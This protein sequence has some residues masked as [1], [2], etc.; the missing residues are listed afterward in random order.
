M[1]FWNDLSKTIYN[2]AG[3]TVK[4]T[5]KLAGIAKIKYKINSLKTKLDFYYK[6]VGEIKFSEYK[7]E[8]ISPETYEGLFEQ[9]DTL[10]IKISELEKKL[11][12]IRE[13]KT[14]PNCAYRVKQ[15]LS[16]CPKCGEKISQ[17]NK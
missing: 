10:N 3:Q 16:F 2:A 9:I 17:D 6:S 4:G 12:D 5:E 7:G 11:S 8:E 15:G 13:Y 1:D 14:C